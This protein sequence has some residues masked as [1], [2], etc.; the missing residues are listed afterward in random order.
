V[1]VSILSSAGLNGGPCK[2]GK[3]MFSGEVEGRCWIAFFACASG[4][5]YLISPVVCDSTFRV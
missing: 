3:A 1:S 5:A 4:I 2:F